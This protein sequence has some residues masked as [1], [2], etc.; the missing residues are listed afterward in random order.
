M[1]KK[2]RREKLSPCSYE[3]EFYEE[4]FDMEINVPKI[5]FDILFRIVKFT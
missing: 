4:D 5:D 2:G 1:G 3:A